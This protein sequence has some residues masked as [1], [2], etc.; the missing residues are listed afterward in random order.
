M[1]RTIDSLAQLKYNHKRRPIVVSCDSS[2]VGSS[3]DRQMPRIVLDILSAD[4]NLD[5]EQLSFQ[6]TVT[7]IFSRKPSKGVNPG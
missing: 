3:N 1:R 5:P 7:S 4:S 2:I 6:V